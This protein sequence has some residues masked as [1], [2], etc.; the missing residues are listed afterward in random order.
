LSFKSYL[1]L[2]THLS[3]L[4]LI[5]PITPYVVPSGASLVA[6]M[7]KLAFNSGDLGSI[8]GSGR[9]TGEG[10]GKPLQYSWQ[11]NC[12]D[13][14]AEWAPVPGAQGVGVTEDPLPLAP[15]LC[16]SP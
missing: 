5:E 6:E 10:H 15:S 7:V 3:V 9:S 11:K 14:G 12:A 4:L 2:K 8:P 13:R 1:P 16:V